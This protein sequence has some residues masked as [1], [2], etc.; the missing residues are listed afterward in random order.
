MHRRAAML[1]TYLTIARRTLARSKGYAFINVAGL[2]VGMACAVLIVLYVIHETGFDAYHP[3]AERIY[4]MET[5]GWATNPA[6]IGPYMTDHFAEAERSARFLRVTRASVARENDFFSEKKFFFADSTAP[7][8]LAMNF[9]LGSPAHALTAPNSVLLTCSTARKYFG[10]ENPLGKTLR[11]ETAASQFFTVTGVTEDVPEQSQFTFDFLASYST[12][13]SVPENDTRPWVQSTVYTYVLLRPGADVPAL[14]RN[15]TSVLNQHLGGE[16]SASVRLRPI[17]EIHTHSD[18]EK[19]IEPLGSARDNFILL[20]IAA[21]VLALAA[22]NFV[23]L[24]T[25]RSLKRAREIAMRKTLGAARGELIGQFMAESTVM[26]ALSAVVAVILCEMLFPSFSSLSGVPLSYYREMWAVLAGVSLVLAIVVGII[27]GAYPAL[28]LSRFQPA[29]LLR[30]GGG[31]DDPSTGSALVRKGLVVFQFT[32]SAA[33]TAG[34]LIIMRQMDYI[35]SKDIGIASGEV[36]VIPISAISADR[37]NAL[38]EELLKNSAVH[39]V[40]A[41]FSVPGERIVMDVVRPALAREKE[42][43]IRMVLADFD[44]PE[45]YGLGLAGGRSFTHDLMTDT[46]GTFMIN[47]KAAALFGWDSPAGHTMEYPGQKKNGPVV[48]VL[49]DFNFASLH[50]PVEP[51]VV[52]LNV[53]ARYFKNIAVRIDPAERGR[54]VRSIQETWKSV[55]PGRPFEY[56]FLDESF[57]GLYAPETKLRAIVSTFTVIGIVVACMGLFGLVT[58]AVEKRVKEIGIR[59]VLGASAGGI[60]GLISADFLKLVILANVIAC[61]IAAYGMNRWLQEFAYRTDVSPWIF[62]VTALATVVLAFF[63]VALQA[64][65]AALANPVESL[66]YE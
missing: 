42:Y 50:A 43:G 60:V 41:S 33:L 2:S 8:V 58:L 57:R 24:S 48:G 27:A 53:N 15:I 4:R 49:K 29:G 22:V 25:A 19:E 44:F 21:L 61:P 12:L 35:R 32:I 65:R 6:A 36:V 64:F 10:D 52:S 28:Y 45:T 46:A 30:T 17:R 56:Y 39:A 1:S 62:A 34:A 23:N 38:K 63:T 47:E 55:L 37:Y 7:A 18:C 13:P 5:A 16:D 14:E 59:K 51:L 20:T 11:V 9:I 54:T 3:D 31:T 40:T 66:R 26:A